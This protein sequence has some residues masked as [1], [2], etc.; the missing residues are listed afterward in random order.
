ML[1]KAAHLQ[2][3]GMGKMADWAEATDNTAIQDV[4]AR[5]KELISMQNA[6]QDTLTDATERCVEVSAIGDEQRLFL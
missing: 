1:K 5:M 4:T 2:K 6:Q 3:H